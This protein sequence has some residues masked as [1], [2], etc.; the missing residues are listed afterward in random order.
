MKIVKLEAEGFKRLRAVEIAPDGNVITIGGKNG[1]GKSSLLDAIWVALAGRAKAPPKPVRQ[2]MERATIKLDLGDLVI[3]RTFTDK[4]DGKPFTDTVKVENA[5]G[6][7]YSKP[8]EMLN[9]LLG[10]VGFDPFEFA[11]LKPAEQAERLLE[12]VPLSIDL[13]EHAELDASDTEKRRDAGRDLRAIE[14]QLADLPLEQIPADAP[15]RDALVAQLGSASSHNL[16]IDREVIRRQNAE[17]VIEEFAQGVQRDREKAANLRASADALEAEANENE[18]ERA[19]LQ[20]AFEKLPPLAEPID[21]HDLQEQIR[22]AETIAAMRARQDARAAKVAERDKLAAEVEGYNNALAERER[23]REEALAKAKMPVEGLGFQIN[24]KGKP[25]VTYQG[26]PFDREQISTAAMLRVSTAIA[27][28]A[29]PTLRVLQIRDG[30]L[31]DDDAMAMLSEMAAE[32]D[33]Q[34]WIERVG[35]QGV[36]IVIEDGAVREEEPAQAQPEPEEGKLV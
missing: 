5:E 36:G 20:E 31:L 34:L 19:R 7:R 8:Q 22:K 30:S 3:S 29:N 11:T 24:E 32:Q 4:G 6:L 23:Q 25:V 10:E 1:A 27:M 21:V 13:D 9:S 15:D 33:Y 14:A 16:E 26:L 35:T 2:G 28:A 18:A 12:L 17:R